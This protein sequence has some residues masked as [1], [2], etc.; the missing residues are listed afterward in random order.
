MALSHVCD[1]GVRV[2]TSVGQ[3]AGAS[4]G[5]SSGRAALAQAPTAAGAPLGMCHSC[6][7]HPPLARPVATAPG[8]CSASTR[9][10]PAVAHRS[11]QPPWHNL[12]SLDATIASD[13]TSP[14]VGGA[15]RQRAATDGGQAH[16]PGQRGRACEAMPHREPS[17]LTGG[18][19]RTEHT[20]EEAT[21]LTLS[22]THAG[23]SP[24]GDRTGGR[25]DEPSGSTSLTA[26]SPGSHQSFGYCWLIQKCRK[27]PLAPG[28]FSSREA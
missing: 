16:G 21:A 7:T 12:C 14:P 27:F 9:R 2:V 17:P 3:P 25:T 6:N 8:R 4:A 15:A 18:T 19:A 28:C 13:G 5:V 26:P 23:L 22:W 24:G 1:E 11:A 20:H 10:V